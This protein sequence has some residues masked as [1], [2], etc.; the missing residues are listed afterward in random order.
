M[1]IQHWPQRVRLPCTTLLS[2]FY[3]HSAQNW[4]RTG[5]CAL[6][7]SRFKCSI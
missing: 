4:P 1:T 2:D 3:L 7:V 5:G 6:Y